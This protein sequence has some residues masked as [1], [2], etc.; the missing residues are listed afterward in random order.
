MIDINYSDRHGF[1]DLG[2]GNWKQMSWAQVAGKKDRW[3]KILVFSTIFS[4]VLVLISGLEL[5]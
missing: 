4:I 3:R 1:Q 5:Q 2:F